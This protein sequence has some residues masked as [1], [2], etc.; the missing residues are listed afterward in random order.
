VTA[1]NAS[2]VYGSANPAFTASYTGQQGTDA[3][4]ATAS[5]SATAASPVVVGG[6][7]IV[8]AVVAIS[9][10]SL[11]NYTVALHNGTLTVTQ[12]TVAVALAQ[13]VP[14]PSESA[15]ESAPRSPRR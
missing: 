10:A 3:F 12:A 7:A 14:R 4:T 5:S 2:R 1:Q 6:Y 11:S 15:L 9:P 13:T 8:P